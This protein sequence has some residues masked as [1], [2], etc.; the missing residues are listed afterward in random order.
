LTHASTALVHY[1][2]A[3]ALLEGPVRVLATRADTSP[4]LARMRRE[5]SG[6]TADRLRLFRAS[7][8]RI[9]HNFLWAICPRT[10]L[11][12][13]RMD[14]ELL[15]FVEY[16]DQDN[17]HMPP[18][19]EG[20]LQQFADFL[21]GFFRAKQL[22]DIEIVFE[23]ELALWLTRRLRRSQFPNRAALVRA[24][25][26]TSCSRKCRKDIPLSLSGEFHIRTYRHDP[27]YVCRALTSRRTT[28]DGGWRPVRTVLYFRSSGGRVCWVRLPDLLGAVLMDLNGTR[29]KK[30]I[31]AVRLKQGRRLR[32][33]NRAVD[34]AV[35]LG[36]ALPKEPACA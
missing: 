36:I 32:D 27:R 1:V 23:H 13:K 33:V 28:R 29:S 2:V 30:E 21:R 26:S 14:L 19:A 9:R 11:A 24:I 10:L 17:T 16:G 5:M 20:R 4:R 6:H 7:L 12:L 3:R 35:R 31:V 18:S 8:L 22:P 34:L 25:R 15:A